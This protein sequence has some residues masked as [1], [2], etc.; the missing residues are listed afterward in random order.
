MTGHSMANER[1]LEIARKGK[2]AWKAWRRD[3]D[4]ALDLSGVDFSLPENR[5]IS[6]VGLELGDGANFRGA[7]FGS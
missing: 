4:E 2:S 1:H 6:F 5:E 7:S 3:P